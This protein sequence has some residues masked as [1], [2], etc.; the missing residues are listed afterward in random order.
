MGSSPYHSVTKIDGSAQKAIANMNRALVIAI[1]L[2]LV[3]LLKLTDALAVEKPPVVNVGY[4]R[5][6]GTTDAAIKYISHPVW[7]IFRLPLHRTTTYY[8]IRYAAPPTGNNRWR[9]P[10]PIEE[11][12]TYSKATTI[13]AMVPGPSCWQGYPQW[14]IPLTV[15]EPGG[16]ED[17]LLLDVIVPETPN[18]DKLPVMFEIHGGGNEHCF[19]LNT[20][21]I[22]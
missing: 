11:Q 4:A 22:C 1:L 8:G 9:P 20:R 7:V 19:N 3:L 18:S 2:R 14:F 13:D 15:A 12:N 5:Y 16:E 17:C 21:S 10:V 6:L